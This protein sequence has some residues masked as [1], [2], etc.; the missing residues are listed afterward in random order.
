MDKT[1]TGLVKYLNISSFDEDWGIAVST[2]GCQFV[3]PSAH[4]PLAEHPE[5]YNFKTDGKRIL[6][7]YQL[8]YITGGKGYFSSRSCKTTL[9][10]AGTMILLFPDE[11]HKYYPDPDTGWDEYWVGFRG[12]HIDNRIAKGFFSPKNCLFRVGIDDK[13]LDVYR[14]IIHYA[15]EERTGYQQLISSIVLQ[16][17]GL[18]YYRNQNHQFDNSHLIDVLNK[19]RVVMKNNIER[20][21]SPQK[22]ALQMGVSYSLFRKEFKRYCGVSPGQ[23]QQQLKLM[24]IKELLSLSRKSISEIAFEMHFE[25]TGQLST[26]FHKK[27]GI[28]PSEFRRRL[29]GDRSVRFPE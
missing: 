11:W 18:A 21:L 4:Y 19:A 1:T 17:L 9:V 20:P 29:H 7:E 10:E 22:I 13:I 8:I 2:V 26:F 12:T 15:D 27:E 28:T 5:S 23:Y 25:S 3:K 24:R 6:N 16:L 14:S